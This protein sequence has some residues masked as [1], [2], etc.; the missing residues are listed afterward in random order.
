MGMDKDK[1]RVILVDD[2]PV[3]LRSLKVAIPWEELS[4]CIAGEA[5]NGEGAL[6]LVN[7]TRPHIIISD[8]R[9]PG[10][11]GITLMKEVMNEHPQLLFIFISGYGEFEY[12]REALREGAFDYLLKP[13][14][15]DE[16]T[17]TV[18][19]AT[20]VLQKQDDNDKLLHSIQVLSML[21]RERMFTEIIEGSRSSLQHMQWLEQSELD[22]GY[23]M[24][25]LQ[26]DQYMKLGGQWGMEEKRLWLFA[27]R[28]I[29]EEWSV[30]NGG[31]TVFPFRS[32]EWVLLFPASMKEK[33]EHLGREVIRLIKDNTKLSASIGFSMSAAGMD[34]LAELYE[35]AVEA[36]YQRFYAGPEGV[37]FATTSADTR[38]AKYPK[39]LET[40]MLESVRTLNL[41]KTQ[42]LWD[43]L[44]D[45]FECHNLSRDN[46]ERMLSQLM[47]VLYRQFEHWGVLQEGDMEQTLQGIQAS[48]TLQDMMIVLKTSL[49]RWMKECSQ[50]HQPKE[51]ADTIIGKTKAYISGHYQQDLS[52]EAAAEAAGLSISHFC[53]L[54]KQVT[55]YTFLE[56][57][58]EYRIE[59]AKSI[60]KNTSVKV[61]QIAPLVGYQD[62]RYFTQVFKKITGRTP[63]E[64]REAV[65]N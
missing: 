12:A 47:V 20:T 24:A 17:E 48:S 34:R 16:L 5:R 7:E 29:L 4:L 37:Y 32:G 49:S 61:Y 9:M 10:I 22:Q 63:T 3:I 33:Q 11:D 18:K 19:R 58:T 13:I 56:Y 23:Y 35:S 51:H 65:L 52:I 54:F 53:T 39:V 62:P 25:V 8:I 6:A 28:N 30:L 2:E 57:L 44:K 15:H 45:Y 40:A 43:Q 42:E 36:L 14:D 1:Y 55:G 41:G 38:E 27:I 64:Y 21:A 26:L 46:T 50:G 59:K 60:L 31:L